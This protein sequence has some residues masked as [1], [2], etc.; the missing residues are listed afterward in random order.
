MQKNFGKL[1]IAVNTARTDRSGG[2]TKSATQDFRRPS[3][4]ILKLLI[5]KWAGV[6]PL[7]VALE[8][9][10]GKLREAYVEK[11]KLVGAD[12]A[13]AVAVVDDDID[14]MYAAL[15]NTSNLGAP[16][17]AVISSEELLA[18]ANKRCYQVP[19]ERQIDTNKINKARFS[20]L[21]SFIIEWAGVNVD[22]GDSSQKPE[23]EWRVT[24]LA[25]RYTANNL[26]DRAS[27][28]AIAEHDV[29]EMSALIKEK[30]GPSLGRK[31]EVV[32]K[33][34]GA[35]VPAGSTGGG[36]RRAG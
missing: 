27:A 23:A 17:T 34:S 24:R 7:P 5:L 19:E 28:L 20:T 22:K 10:K 12:K 9:D 6:E 31:P 36:A 33:V 15:C 16:R 14:A 35:T 13:V 26:T 18:E 21:K 2:Y 32:V 3:E 8:Y 1:L 11:S 25:D 4:Q 30:L 29:S